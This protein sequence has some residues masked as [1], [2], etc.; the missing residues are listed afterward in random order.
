VSGVCPAVAMI[1][2]TQ[3]WIRRESA[4]PRTIHGISLGH[5]APGACSGSYASDFSIVSNKQGDVGRSRK[6]KNTLS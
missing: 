1:R 3:S 5:H 4:M 2:L 6:V